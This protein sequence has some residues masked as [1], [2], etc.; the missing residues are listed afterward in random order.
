MAKNPWFKFYPS[1]WRGSTRLKLC[2]AGA[3]ALL[4]EMM[5]IMHE[6]EPYGHLL[7]AGRAVTDVDLAKQSGLPTKNVAAWRAELLENGLIAVNDR[8]VTFNPRMVRDE[9]VRKRRADG[10]RKGGNPALKDN[11]KVNVE[12]YPSPSSEGTHQ[13]P[14]T[15]SQKPELSVSKETGGPPRVVEIPAAKQSEGEFAG[16]VRKHFWLGN[17]TPALL[18]RSKPQWHMGNEITIGRQWA[19][20]YG[21]W[22]VVNGLLPLFRKVLDIEVDQPLSCLFFHD[23]DGRHKINQVLGHYQR[24][25]EKAAGSFNLRI[26]A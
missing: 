17:E 1:D 23:K 26:G 2:S 8:G 10:G 24:L 20:D 4:I 13:I 14:D 6:A 16:L 9:D 15:R 11:G 5:C 12:G 3:R 18:L 7:I 25:Q 21:G 22:E 19:K